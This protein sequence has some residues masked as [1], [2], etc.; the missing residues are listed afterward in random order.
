MTSIKV[1]AALV[2]AGVLALTGCGS[3]SGS[4]SAGTLNIVGF[5]V[6]E[7]ANQKVFAAFEKTAAGKGW[8]LQG[9]Y[10]ASG[11]ERDAV[12]G[13]QKAD[14][15]HLSL[16][17]DVAKL[18][19]AGKVASSWADNATKGICTDSV[20][21]FGVQ[22]G[23]PKGIK[24]WDDLLKPGVQIVTPDP[25]SSG[26]AKWN[27]LAAYGAY[28]QETGSPA[29][30]EA[31]MK[32]FMANVVSW[33]SSGRDATSAFENGTG[34]VLLSYENEM[35]LARQSGQ[36]IDYTDPDTSLLIENPC[37]VTK[38][39]PKAASD[40]LAFQKSAA[41]QKLYVETGFRPLAGVDTG[42]VTVKGANDPSNPFPTIAH[43]QTI[44]KDFGGWDS[45]NTKYFDETNGILTKLKADYSK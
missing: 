18:V 28:L 43:L 1:T 39:A 16:E 22:K 17:P 45:A 14:E 27:L 3:N 26:S 29:G 24:T 6:M 42:T 9:A 20:V 11:T 4:S 30:A 7:Q 40:F 38:D 44:D 35:I 2:A 8:N 34:D 25:G 10:G 41:G 36:S 13:G 15:V 21:V 37:A 12:I 19:D 31:D 33:P 23:N 5:S 32:K